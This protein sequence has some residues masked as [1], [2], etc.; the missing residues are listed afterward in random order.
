MQE[1]TFW[2]PTATV[3]IGLLYFFLQKKSKKKKTIPCTHSIAARWQLCQA[4]F[5]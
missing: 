1:R 4:H 5:G 2:L 3:L